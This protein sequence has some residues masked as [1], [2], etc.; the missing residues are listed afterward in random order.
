MTLRKAAFGLLG[1]TFLAAHT[2]YSLQGDN[3][4]TNA[5]GPLENEVASAG[6]VSSSA[7]VAASTTLAD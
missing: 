4:V 2:I 5:N 1:L 6:T 7:C 3:G